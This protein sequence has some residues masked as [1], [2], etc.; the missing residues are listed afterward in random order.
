MIEINRT[1]AENEQIAGLA[2]QWGCS[3]D[4]AD[5][6]TALIER[7]MGISFREVAALARA[8]DIELKLEIVNGALSSSR[9]L[10]IKV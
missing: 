10:D 1:Q 2:A 5:A 7:S 4:D 9:I 6:I 8:G 3:S